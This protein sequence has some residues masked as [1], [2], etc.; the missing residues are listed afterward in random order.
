MLDKPFTYACS[1]ASLVVLD[2]QS[3]PH[4]IEPYGVPCHPP[5]VSDIA[6]SH[7]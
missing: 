3:F 2:D 1:R 5:P 4:G 7:G 6:L